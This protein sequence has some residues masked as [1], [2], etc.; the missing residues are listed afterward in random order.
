M[1]VEVNDLSVE[2]IVVKTENGFKVVPLTKLL[3]PQIDKINENASSIENLQSALK[4]IQNSN[5]PKRVA[6]L[7]KSFKEDKTKATLVRFMA[8]EILNDDINYNG[9]DYPSDYEQIKSWV[10]KPEGTAPES[11]SKYLKLA[12]GEEESTTEETSNG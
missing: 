9:K 6:D 11:F 1:L 4:E 10:F 3:K 8:F 7:E 2:G 5:I 12:A